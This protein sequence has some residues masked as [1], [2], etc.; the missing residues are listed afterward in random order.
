MNPY[1]VLIAIVLPFGL[2]LMLLV[3]VILTIY[4]KYK[5]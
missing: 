3:S 4:R 2:P 1:L 5:K